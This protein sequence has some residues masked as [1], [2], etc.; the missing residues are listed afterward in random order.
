M[1]AKPLDDVAKRY[2]APYYLKMMGTNASRASEVLLTDVAE[3]SRRVAAADVLRLLRSGGWRERVMGAWY[4]TQIGGPEVTAAVLQAVRTSR[5]AL[6]APALATAAI[7]LAGADAIEALEHYFAA[8]QAGQWGAAGLIA[9]AADHLREHAQA[10]ST[11][12]TP[13][14]ADTEAFRQLIDVTRR[15]RSDEGQC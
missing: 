8:D 1:T 9:A 4:A 13:S 15:L 7:I 3:A 2:V 12:P 6:D 14:P 5:G 11:L 10:S